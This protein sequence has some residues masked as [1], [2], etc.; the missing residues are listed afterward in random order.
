MDAGEVRWRVSRIVLVNKYSFMIRGIKNGDCVLCSL[1]VR[2]CMSAYWI[3][4]NSELIIPNGE[5]SVL[6]RR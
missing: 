4:I 3:K 6:G 1:I 5:V 2:V